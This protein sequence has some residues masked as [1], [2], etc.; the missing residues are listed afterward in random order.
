MLTYRQTIVLFSLKWVILPF[1]ALW[2]IEELYSQFNAD[3]IKPH[4][5]S[6]HGDISKGFSG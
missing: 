6:E 4:C 2:E 3:G 5:V 1:Y